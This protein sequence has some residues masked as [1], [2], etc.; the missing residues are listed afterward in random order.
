MGYNTG[1]ARKGPA[2]NLFLPR[3]EEMTKAATMQERRASCA[4]P[5]VICSFDQESIDS[6]TRA[7]IH[8]SARF[9]YFKHGRGTMEID[10]RAYAIVPD[11][12]VAITPW[13]ITDVTEVCETL[14][15]QKIVYDYQLMNSLLKSI[16]GIDRGE[17]EL[18]ALLAAEPV[19][20]LDETQA[21]RT[22]SLM[23]R[24][25]EE[26]GIESARLAAKERPMSQLYAAVML[27]ELMIL[28]HRFAMSSRGRDGRDAAPPQ[29][30]SPLSY[31]YAHSAEKLTLSKVAE[32]FFTSPSTLS[33]QL[34]QTTSSSFAKLLSGI[35]AE[36]AADYLI[37][38]DLT[39]DEI[40]ALTGFVD[41]SHVSRHFVSE[42]GITPIRY[43]KIY[44]KAM[45]RLSRSDK[46]LAF[47]LTDH[48]YKNY[49]TEGLNA[50]DTAQRFGLSVAEM[51]R[52]LLYYAEKN[53]DTLLNFVRVNRACELLATTDYYI[54]DV[55]MTVGYSNVKTFN[56]NFYK[57][58]EMTPSEFRERVAFQA[59]DGSEKAAGKNKSKKNT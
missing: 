32:V 11:T 44:S 29:S 46:A 34:A 49:E 59:A 4:D 15:L 25:A 26:L 13:V 14:Q 10:G 18:L 43:R 16:P 27:S 55:A 8:Q 22:D 50:A 38:T 31:I 37:Y 17:T 5:T 33:K 2:G 19:V 21:G 41:A 9:L 53:F 48:I 42:F 35:R 23:L 47:A 58:K 12:L 30:S 54:I 36:K 1:R 56:M 39:L 24:F 52:L 45:T 57:F 7:L 28:Y 6:P 20:Y 51:N 40:A 3:Y